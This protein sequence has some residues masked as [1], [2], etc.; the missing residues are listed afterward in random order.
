MA[1]VT[2]ISAEATIAYLRFVECCTGVEI[3]FR[4]SLPIING[5]VYSYEGTS[6]YPGTGGTLET[7]KC[8]S[9]FQEYTSS[10]ITYPGAPTLPILSPKQGCLDGK[11][12][13]CNPPQPCP[14]PE[15]FEFIEGECVNITTTTATYS[16]QLIQL[17]AGDTSR[18]YC[19]SG[20]RLY[21][22]ITAMTWPIYGYGSSNALYTL[23]QNN[24]A[25]PVVIPIANVQNEVWG[26]GTAPCS[27]VTNT[28]C[29]P[30]TCGGRL[31]I[32]G[33]GSP[34]FPA[35]QELAFEFCINVEGP[36]TKQYM[37]GIAGDNYVKFY[38]DGNLAV[39]LNVPGGG[40][41]TPFRHWH[42]F[43]ITLTPGTHT[44]KLAGLNS[45]AGTD[46]AFAAEIYDTTLSYF[47]ANLM[48][49][50]V[51]AGN[52]GTSPA[53][54]EPFILFSTRDMVGQSVANP[55]QP[56]T[57]SCP[58]GGEVI[59]CNGTPSCLITEK[60]TLTCAC[61]MIIPCD[62]SPTFI[63]N[64]DAFEPYVDGFITVDSKEYT[65]C[66]YIVKLDDNECL[67]SVDAFPNPDI[68]CDCDLNCYYVSNTNGF[69]YVDNN[70][71]LIE[72]TA[73][74]NKPYIKICSK[75]YPVV[76]NDSQ[77]YTIVKLGIC[78]IEKDVAKC[79]T[80]CFK[81]TN[82]EN[83]DVVIY[84]NSDSLLPYAFGTNNIVRLLGKEGCWEVSLSQ[85]NCDCI[86]VTFTGPNGSDT[87]TANS[88]GT[89]NGANLYQ[90]TANNGDI[91][92][93]WFIPEKGWYITAN[94]Y[95]DDPSAFDVAFTP[96][97]GNCPDS[98]NE[99]FIWTPSEFLEDAIETERCPSECECPIDVTVTTGY[100]TCEDCIGYVAYK[101]TSCDNNDVIYTL[102]NLEAYIGQVVK[103]DCGCYNVEQINYLPPN[104]QIIKL[105]DVYTNCLECSRTYWKLVDC[106]EEADPIITYT[107][108][109]GYVGK[110][111]KIKDCDECW[112]IEPTTEHAGAIPVL[113][114]EE[115]VD[116]EDCGT[117]LPCTCSTITNYSEEVKTYTYLS[118][119]KEYETITLQPHERSDRV[120]VLG[121]VPNRECCLES[122]LT[123]TVEKETIVYNWKFELTEEI[124]NGKP[125]Y[126]SYLLYEVGYEKYIAYK[127]YYQSDGCWYAVPYETN[128]ATSIVPVF[129][130]CNTTD[131]PVGVWEQFDCGCISFGF[132]ICPN[133][134]SCFTQIYTFSFANYDQNGNPVYSSGVQ[135][136]LSYNVTLSRWEI[137]DVIN[138]NEV[139]GFNPS[140]D[141]TCPFNTVVK[142]WFSNV[143]NLTISP[144][145][146]RVTYDTVAFETIN[147]EPKCDCINMTLEFVGE[148]QD[149]AQAYQFILVPTGNLFNGKPTYEATLPDAS[150]NLYVYYDS[151][152][153]K[154]YA[155]FP[156]DDV[157]YFEI[158]FNPAYPDCPI[159]DWV[160]I[161]PFTPN[162]INYNPAPVGPKENF[163]S[164]S[165]R[166]KAANA[167]AA[168]AAPKNPFFSAN[169]KYCTDGTSGTA[170]DPNTDPFAYIQFFGECQHGV[171]L[172][173]TFKNN[174]T[175][176]P[177]Y[178][179]PNCNPDEY[180]KITCKFSQIM[181]KVVLEKRYGI[182]NC[183]PDEDEKWL[184]KK[185]LVDLQALKDPNYCCPD[186]PCSCNSGKSYSSCNC[187]N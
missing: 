90:F 123:A 181:Y 146:C 163:A 170:E 158:P 96:F 72:V 61:Y 5:S 117:N 46:F 116:C 4:G 73:I 148:P 167:E 104:P 147:C 27:T 115:Y 98:I 140:N 35:N 28:L 184:L 19:D 119:D 63:S 83:K 168:A 25:G 100:T 139:V 164:A 81:L 43:P 89:F 133:P 114:I 74:Q 150:E 106:L 18:Y 162:N 9:V 171:C 65:G 141:S 40:V 30:G 174:R 22:D 155:Y 54:L 176:K 134:N 77:N 186:C 21:P 187:G 129:K 137:I 157:V 57:W 185:E 60:I 52:C 15:G 24:G 31:N 23:N 105:E 152:T 95:G 70:N 33:V 80:L 130:L 128:E 131:C 78:T 183:C 2:A 76:E 160:V 68:P 14:C 87:Y 37:L 56:G 165:Y 29:P 154:W 38:I 92:Y 145:Q 111:V 1:N 34:S 138:N 51:S 127:I 161:E 149:V 93:V 59:F 125:V 144:R 97:T 26:K 88:I 3:F 169:T 55:N 99:D 53:Q 86:N 153:N 107:D 166:A 109:T 64:N 182:T 66:A 75:V 156:A 13:S 172:P 10:T 50:A 79:S 179:T 67:E 121:W 32:A 177:G 45:T 112:N 7:G 94:G 47:Q 42:T 108:L 122:T 178:N 142:Q 16:G 126:I 69:L 173:P 12:P 6:P 8:Y 62:G 118:C 180:D 82:C 132:T 175:V 151:N 48:A 120:C 17:Q 136:E 110:T 39:F 101:L 91:L 11:C 84:S 124:I 44:I 20:L 41:T 85:G 58:D 102:L 135:Y 103:L 36:E 113:V 143:P 71:E 49:P 159:G